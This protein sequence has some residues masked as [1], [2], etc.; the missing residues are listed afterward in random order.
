MILFT[1]NHLMINYTT[2]LVSASTKKY[3][4]AARKLRVKKMRYII[5]LMVTCVSMKHKIQV[6]HEIQK[7]SIF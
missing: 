4:K 3:C 6:I 5:F 2:L 7:V 1:D